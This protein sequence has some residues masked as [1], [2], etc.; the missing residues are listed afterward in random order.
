MK[1]PELYKKTVDILYD[2]YFN[3]TLEHWNCT[4]CAVGNIVAAN[5]GI[6]IIP[7]R[8]GFVKFG[9]PP[10]SDAFSPYE[11]SGC[12]F[13]SIS[14][15]SVNTLTKAAKKQ[16]AATGYSARELA[17]IEKAFENCG[18]S[19][20]SEDYMFNGLVAVLEVLKEIHEVTDEPHTEN[21]TRFKNHY[22]TL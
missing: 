7:V 8:R 15:G 5:M 16:V 2:A 22:Q 21:V 1:N 4:A 20:S 17:K 9:N 14:Y 19:V 12:W 13:P 3:D 6:K 10:G 11:N 18:Y